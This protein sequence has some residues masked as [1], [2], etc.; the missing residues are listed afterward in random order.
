M[1]NPET[2]NTVIYYSL[3]PIITGALF[4]P[5]V[6]WLVLSVR[7][8]DIVQIIFAA[9]ITVFTF[10]LF[11]VSLINL[12]FVWYCIVDYQKYIDDVIHDPDFAILIEGLQGSGKTDTAKRRGVIIAENNWAEICAEYTRLSHE[13]LYRSNDPLWFEHYLEVKEVFEY[14]AARPEIFPCLISD[15]PMKVD[16]RETLQFDFGMLLQRKRVPFRSVILLDEMKN[17]GLSNRYSGKIP[18][19]LDETIR[20]LRQFS[21]TKII[22]TEQ[23]KFMALLEYRNMT[24]NYTM[25]SMQTVLRPAILSWILDRKICWFMRKHLPVNYIDPNIPDVIPFENHD[26]VRFEK[27]YGADPRRAMKI[28]RFEELVNSIGFVRYVMVFRGSTQGNTVNDASQSAM[29]V[30]IVGRKKLWKYYMPT[31]RRYT[32]DTRLFRGINRAK[33][34]PIDLKSWSDRST[35]DRDYWDDL[36]AQIDNAITQH[37]RK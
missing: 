36:N 10:V 31:Y 9:A 11:L 8:M 35:I 29:D 7:S 15:V 37:K 18:R 20:F 1:M 19:E 30:E 16:G 3:K 25:Q 28:R 17:C 14:Y 26:D 23:N 21:E 5:A 22:A 33:D 24:S 4:A 27:L 34:L 2:K 12:T 6:V 32:S 13:F